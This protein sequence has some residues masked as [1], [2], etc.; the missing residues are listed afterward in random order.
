MT[1]EPSRHIPQAWREH[2]DNPD[3]DFIDP[4]RLIDCSS[5]FHQA[6]QKSLIEG[7]VTTRVPFPL[8]IYRY[9]F[10]DKGTEDEQDLPF[11]KLEKEDLAT[12]E[13]PSHWW[14]KLDRNGQGTKI[15]FPIK[16]K[17][18]L[19]FSNPCYYVEDGQLLKG[20]R[21]PKESLIV[22]FLSVATDTV[23]LTIN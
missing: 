18:M 2:F 8:D 21:L 13:L 15:L 10:K 14:Y 23:T 4:Q 3:V 17:P 5:T 22:K 1:W 20:R 16:V 11:V 12:L 19:S 9:V 6:I 7:T